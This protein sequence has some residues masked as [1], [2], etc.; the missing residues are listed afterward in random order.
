MNDPLGHTAAFF[1]WRRAQTLGDLAELTARWCEGHLARSAGYGGPPDPET[2]PLRD[3][4]ARTNRA[5]LL[6]VQSQP[7]RPTSER[8]SLGCLWTAQRAILIALAPAPVADVLAAHL[9]STGLQVTTAVAG[10]PTLPWSSRTPVTV[11]GGR[12]HTA[13]AADPPIGA[14]GAF[15]GWLSPAARRAV[16]QATTV[17]VVDPVWGRQ[18]LL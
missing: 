8:G 11:D 6:T 9:A 10:G 15:P 4:L 7:S 17:C 16:E 3:L 14:V 1:A 18:A 5:G 13:V 12:V 2:G